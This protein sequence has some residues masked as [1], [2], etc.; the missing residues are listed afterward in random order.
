MYSVARRTGRARTMDCA[1]WRIKAIWDGTLVQTRAGSHRDAHRSAPTVSEHP[2]G[3]VPMVPMSSRSS[4]GLT[5][6]GNEAV[7]QCSTGQ[8]CCDAN[9]P[10]LSGGQP[11]CDSTSE[12][13][14]I[15]GKSMVNGT[16]ED[17]SGS[18][19]AGGSAAT[20]ESSDDDTSSSAAAAATFF[21][22]T[23]VSFA[24]APSSRESAVASVT[25]AKANTRIISST[26]PSSS[27]VVVTEIISPGAASA[28]TSTFTSLIAAG[29]AATGSTSGQLDNGDSNSTPIGTIVGAAVGGVAGLLILALLAFLLYRHRRR[30]RQQ[31]PTQL[32]SPGSNVEP[33]YKDYR[34][35]ASPYPGHKSELEGSSPDLTA[36]VA[37][38]RWGRNR[39]GGKYHS[40]SEVGRSPT[41]STL[42]PTVGRNYRGV[43]GVTQISGDGSAISNDAGGPA[44]LPAEERQDPTKRLSELPARSRSGKDL[45]V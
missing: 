9:R 7:L 21:E 6:V 20:S 35:P 40:P 36:A 38:K 11:C 19:S 4:L 15:E 16:S 10:E 8:F 37:E 30:R 43:S 12:R 25:S 22:S 33:M 44:E 27:I 34:S 42:S 23:V 5:A 39:T 2:E 3:F 41:V 14:S 1:F 31:Q 26:R 18:N 24:T 28:I 17:D 45:G 13:F 29:A 32:F